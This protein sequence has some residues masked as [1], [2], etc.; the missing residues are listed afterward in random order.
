MKIILVWVMVMT[1][2][3][4]TYVYFRVHESNSEMIGHTKTHIEKSPSVMIVLICAKKVDEYR[5][6]L[7]SLMKVRGVNSYEIVVSQ[8]NN[9][10]D[11]RAVTESFGLKTIFHVD[12]IEQTQRLARHFKWTFN[13]VFEVYRDIDG[14][15]VI[16]DDLLL[17][18][19]FLEY[20]ELTI[21][22]LKT[23][24]KLKSV[25]A[26]NDNSFSGVSKTTRGLRRTTF[27][28]GLGWYLSR[29]FWEEELSKMWPNSDWD[30]KVRAYFYKNSYEVIIPE[31]SRDYHVAKTG[32][33]MNVGLF[34][35]YFRN[36]YY[37]TDKD[38]RWS[39]NDVIPVLDYETHLKKLFDDTEV[40][41]VWIQKKDRKQQ[42]MIGRKYGIWW[43]IDRAAW[44]GIRLLWK[45]DTFHMLIDVSKCPPYF[46]PR[47]TL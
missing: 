13:A 33:Y 18:P 43:E 2:L 32:T 37:N 30:W 9:D 28:P 10:K 44:R 40:V 5:K 23:D 22:I 39:S 11:V 16:E 20:F 34:N 47:E 36:I 7:E 45:G 4:N 24:D 1:V 42:M 46:L 21:P 38:F 35:Q 25:S 15:I 6:T 26:W 41:K 29:E 8:S 14:V 17:S 12:P 19:D 3:F 31:V 27:F